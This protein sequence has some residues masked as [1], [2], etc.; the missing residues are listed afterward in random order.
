MIQNILPVIKKL[1]GTKQSNGVNI[2]KTQSK[3]IRVAI[4][5]GELKSRETAS[6]TAGNVD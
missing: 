4:Q 6:V 2:P 5:I 1:N 3:T